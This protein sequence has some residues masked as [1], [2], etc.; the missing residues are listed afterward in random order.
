MSVSDFLD[1]ANYGAVLFF[2]IVLSLCLADL[3]FEDHKKEYALTLAGFFA[4]HALFYILTDSTTL[5]KS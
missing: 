5:Y 1:F 2:G 3:T 4:A